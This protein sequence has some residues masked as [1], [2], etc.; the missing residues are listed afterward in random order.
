M[1]RDLIKLWEVWYIIFNIIIFNHEYNIRAFNA[2]WVSKEW[3]IITI[4]LL[5]FH[6]FQTNR[7]KLH[8]YCTLI[9]SALQQR[10]RY[11][12]TVFRKRGTIARSLQI[13][14]RQLR[15]PRFV[16]KVHRR[17]GLKNLLCSIRLNILLGSSLTWTLLLLCWYWILNLSQ[18]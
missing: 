16:A 14:W 7:I 17:N 10:P 6:F 5:R 3:Q 9:K 2:R 13:L 1:Y 18:N 15:G 4:R 11:F 8:A 12:S